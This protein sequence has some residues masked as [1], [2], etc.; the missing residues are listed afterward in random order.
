MRVYTHLRM[1][2]P[3]LLLARRA[4]D[5]CEG[6]HTKAARL[7][8][9]CALNN[10]V[11]TRLRFTLSHFLFL[12]FSLSLSLSPLCSAAGSP[13]RRTPRNEAAAGCAERGAQRNGSVLLESH[14]ALR[15]GGG[16]GSPTRP[17][18]RHECSPYRGATHTMRT[19]GRCPSTRGP[20]HLLSRPCHDRPIRKN[21]LIAVWVQVNSRTHVPQKL[22]GLYTPVPIQTVHYK[23]LN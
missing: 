6:G 11:R 3:A 21:G 15:G 18:R 10:L 22:T 1:H 7:R 8:L 16:L 5:V 13:P 23:P 9:G 17:N 20:F 4:V 2:R 14:P 12:S 19:F